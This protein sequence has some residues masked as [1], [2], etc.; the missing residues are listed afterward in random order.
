MIIWF[1]SLQFILEIRMLRLLRDYA[2]VP[3]C[4]NLAKV[5][6][7]PVIPAETVNRRYEKD[8]PKCTLIA[9]ELSA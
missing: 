9:Q 8:S 3:V 1:H 6:F 4:E 7:R 2:K 5:H